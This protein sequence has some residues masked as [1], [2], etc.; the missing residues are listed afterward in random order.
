[1]GLL[2]GGP[3]GRRF[4]I[5]TPLPADFR[6]LYLEAVRDNAFVDQD[7]SDGEPRVG[8]VNV[9]DVASTTFELND[10]LVDRYLAFTLRTD[11]KKVQGTYL[12]IALA[13]RE[14]EVCE[15]QGLDKLS[16]GEREV[17]KEALET[18][19]FGRALPSVSTTDVCWDIHTGE[20]TVFSTSE[21]TIEHVRLLM[22]DTFGV[23]IH[24]ERLCDWAAD[25]I[26][27]KEL[28]ERTEAHLGGRSSSDDTVVDGHHEGDPL[29]RQAFGLG[30]DFLTWLWLRGEASEGIFRVLDARGAREE[31][32]RKRGADSGEGG[33]W[34]DV[35]E[36][37][38]QSDLNLWID[39]RLKLRELVEDDP[40][41]TIL[42][43]ASPAASPEAR[44]NLNQGK[45]PVEAR[46]GMKL[47]DLECHL[48]L[49]ASPDGLKVS[50]I[51]LPTVVNS[52]RDEKLLER[53]VL[54][55]LLHITIKQ[56]FQQ[57]FL[58][59]TSPDWDER[60]TGWLAEE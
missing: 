45:R 6:D 27:W 58:A 38:R 48:S 18:A 19:L 56:L 34:D 7:A 2:A 16:K 52:G 53:A 26:G 12:K 39:S 11:V 41:T 60:V 42:L 29:E 57:F 44:R 13:Q 55:D 59:R 43:G 1:M 3:N 49:Q 17:L 4:R 37:L 24:P 23:R 31:A 32:L 25:K 28:G 20:V 5:T 33:Q 21:A 9:F 46:I 8:W 40:S 35:T 47:N 10:L 51:K 36:S 50:S 30:S 22:R 15:E 54:L 14:K